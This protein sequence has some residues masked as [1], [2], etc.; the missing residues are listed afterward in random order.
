MPDD[1][2]ARLT[3][4]VQGEGGVPFDALVHFARPLF[5]AYDVDLDRADALGRGMD[6]EAPED[7][8]LVLDT[9]RLLW[10]YLALDADAAYDALPDLE[11]TLMPGALREEERDAFR[12]LLGQL[13]ER[14][15]D[16]PDVQQATPTP[17]HEALRAYRAL[18]PP[19]DP[20][21]DEAEA[22]ARFARP[23]LDA[24]PPDD[25]DEL[26][27]RMDLAHAL[28]DA[29]HAPEPERPALLEDVQARFGEAR[30]Q[31]L[32]ADLLRAYGHA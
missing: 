4:L 29:A 27:R 22:I 8:L 17:F 20:R 9:A 25:L 32:L 28:W 31:A 24:A 3:A 7:V 26:D 1:T 19:E 15:L 13:E 23:L 6:D 10:A 2:H 14:Y 5:E 12:V 16:E 18:Y 30:P 21:D 11:A